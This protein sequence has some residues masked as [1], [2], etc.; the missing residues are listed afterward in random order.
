MTVGNLNPSAPSGFRDFQDAE[1]QLRFPP[2]FCSAAAPAPSVL[3][4]YPVGCPHDPALLAHAKRQSECPI[5]IKNT[6]CEDYILCQHDI[7]IM[8]AADG[9]WVSPVT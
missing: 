8:G 9:S 4:M 1:S 5:P 3:C 6:N 7:K 2:F